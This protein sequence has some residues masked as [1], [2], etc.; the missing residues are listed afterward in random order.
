MKSTLKKNLIL[1]F[2][3]LNIHIFTHLL[4]LPIFICFSLN[5]MKHVTKKSKMVQYLCIN[6]LQYVNLCNTVLLRWVKK[7]SENEY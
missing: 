5:L 2:E 4:H 3:I 6:D 7:A 1:N